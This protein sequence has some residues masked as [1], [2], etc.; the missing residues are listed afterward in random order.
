LV[1]QQSIPDKSIADCVEA[2]IG[3]YL[4]STG[5]FGA[6]LFMSWLGMR[7]L[8]SKMIQKNEIP[9][10]G[11]DSLFYMTIPDC[12]NVI[13][14]EQ[15]RPPRSPLLR[16]TSDC[17]KQLTILLK[18]NQSVYVLSWKW[19]NWK[20]LNY[21]LVCFR[22]M[23]H[24]RILLGTSSMIGATFSKPLHMLPTPP[25]LSQTAINVLNFW[26]TLFSVRVGSNSSFLCIF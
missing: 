17:E 23:R 3:A 22:A 9:E 11:A 12:E 14:F 5:T 26:V 2:L 4:T 8:P 21:I 15:L 1:T 24:L 20:S 7:V 25:I 16:F 18:V 6:L 10:K 13:L 19:L